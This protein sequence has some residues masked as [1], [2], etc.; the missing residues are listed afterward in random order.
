MRSMLSYIN[1]YFHYLIGSNSGND[2]MFYQGTIAVICE[3]FVTF[4]PAKF[5]IKVPKENI[6]L[7]NRQRED[8]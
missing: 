3:I 1:S 2:R 7:G 6:I 5:Y 4:C 8:I